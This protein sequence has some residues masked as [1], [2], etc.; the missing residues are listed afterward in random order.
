MQAYKL[1]MVICQ[2]LYGTVANGNWFEVEQAEYDLAKEIVN[3]LFN[4]VKT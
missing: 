3:T 1:Q 4:F 2:H